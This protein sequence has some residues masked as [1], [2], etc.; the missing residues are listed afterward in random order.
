MSTTQPGS[1]SAGLAQMLRDCV[2]SG[3]FE[4]NVELLGAETVFDSSSERGRR[5]IAGA[6]AIIDH[7]SAPGPGDVLEWDAREWDEGVAITFEWQGAGE[8]DRRRWYV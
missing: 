2:E 4:A 3:R 5:R 8:T 1:G 6:N 7:L